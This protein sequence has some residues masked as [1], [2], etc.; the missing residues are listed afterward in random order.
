M[1]KLTLKQCSSWELVQ[2]NYIK[3]TR[4][5]MKHNFYMFVSLIA[6]IFRCFLKCIYLRKN[7][8]LIFVVFFNNFDILI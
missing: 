2:N 4:G 6:F 7:I 8:K 3:N 1:L 5:Y